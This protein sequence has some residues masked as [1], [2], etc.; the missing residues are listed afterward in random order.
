MW[1]GAAFEGIPFSSV[2][3]KSYKTEEVFFL[4]IAVYTSCSTF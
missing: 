1:F 3:F 4:D 2:I